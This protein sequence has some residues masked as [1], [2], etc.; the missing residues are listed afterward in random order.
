MNDQKIV[1]FTCN[2]SAYSGMETAGRNRLYYSADIR[3]V[4]IACLGRL[5][6]GLILKAFE[7]GA[8][9]VLMIGCAP[10]E[11]HFDFDYH[12]AE[13]VFSLSKELIKLLGFKDNQLQLD[14]VA[15]GDGEGF[16][17]KVKRFV[18]GLNG[19]TG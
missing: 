4:R 19:Q 6:P 3:P 11:C 10:G 12:N 18:A 15:A 1:V 14:H 9:G 8:R 5:H 7:Y 13:S 16:V 2:W 17:H